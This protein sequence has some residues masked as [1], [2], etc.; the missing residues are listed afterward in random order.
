MDCCASARPEEIAN[1]GAL[2]QQLTLLRER[3]WERLRVSVDWATRLRM[4]CGQSRESST[5]L[6]HFR[7]LPLCYITPPFRIYYQSCVYYTALIYFLFFPFPIFRHCTRSALRA[8]EP[9][10]SYATRC[11]KSS[12]AQTWYISKFQLKSGGIFSFFFVG[13]TRR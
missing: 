6:G 9:A 5:R 10:K 12:R 1:G 7:Q 2:S 4:R 3:S 11:R 8:T 13:S